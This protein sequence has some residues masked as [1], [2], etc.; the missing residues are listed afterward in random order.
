MP[1][2][3][4]IVNEK[5]TSR[6]QILHKKRL[7]SVRSTIDNKRPLIPKAYKSKGCKKFRIEKDRLGEIKKNNRVLL[8]KMMFIDMEK[9]DLNPSMIHMTKC[10]SA[11]SLNRNTRM[12]ALTKVTKEN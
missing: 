2:S 5:F 1:F 7:K 3:N 8:R 6:Q 4:R 9:S 11:F 12:E 10:P